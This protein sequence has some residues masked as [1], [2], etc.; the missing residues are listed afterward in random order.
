MGIKPSSSTYRDLLSSSLKYGLTNGTE[1]AA[2]ISVTSL[3]I[4]LARNETDMAGR[5]KAVLTV[6]LFDK[7]F[8]AYENNKLPGGEM[9]AKVLI[10]SYEV[11][12][13]MADECAQMIEANGEYAGLVRS[14]GGS[15]H[16][17]L[18]DTSVT[19]GAGTHDVQEELGGDLE[20]PPTE[21]PV[22]EVSEV[23]APGGATPPPPSAIFIGH[24]KNKQ[25]LE[26]LKSILDGFK[27]PYKVAIAEPNLGRPIPDKVREVMLSCNSAVLIFTKDEQFSDAD[28]NTIWR[29]SENV[30]HELGAASFQ[31]QDRVVILKEEG[32][33]LPSNFSSV[34]YISFDSGALQAKTM[35]ILKEL[36]GF[37]L[38]R[39]ALGTE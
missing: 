34:G 30:I 19:N 9:L 28:G 31:Y 18:S 14:I 8:R 6:P 38:V 2:S 24:G 32:I 1:K 3:G 39:I 26:D 29:P 20:P 16:I 13:A 15:P 12:Q 27:I 25:P 35:D 17:L 33:T 21:D 36:I 23:R 5:Q 11:P 37:G 4:D 10:A 7:F 22:V